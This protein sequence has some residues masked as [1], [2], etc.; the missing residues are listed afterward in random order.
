[1]MKCVPGQKNK[2]TNKHPEQCR[3]FPFSRAESPSQVKRKTRKRKKPSHWTKPFSCFS[4]LYQFLVPGVQLSYWWPTRFLLQLNTDYIQSGKGLHS[5]PAGKS[6]LW[7]L[8]FISSSAP[9]LGYQYLNVA[10]PPLSESSFS[11]HPLATWC[12]DWSWQKARVLNKTVPVKYGW[13][14]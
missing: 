2:Q 5:N 3:L 1:M 12:P 10:S 8:H 11:V 4:L 13:L 6:F 9:P 14:A 7:G